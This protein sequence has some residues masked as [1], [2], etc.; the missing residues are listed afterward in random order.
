[1]ALVS[2]QDVTNLPQSESRLVVGVCAS[3]APG[4]AAEV[5]GSI[6]EVLGR[7]GG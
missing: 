6:G 1:M 2:P 4:D 7:V 3:V 5:V